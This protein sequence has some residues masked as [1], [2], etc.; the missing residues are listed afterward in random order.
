MSG[1]LLADLIDHRVLGDVVGWTTGELRLEVADVVPAAAGDFAGASEL[2]DRAWYGARPT[3]AAERDRF[4]AFDA[5]VLA[6][7]RASAPAPALVGTG[8]DAGGVGS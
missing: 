4:M 7:I 3:A 8:G 6:R 2:F 1:R 5:A